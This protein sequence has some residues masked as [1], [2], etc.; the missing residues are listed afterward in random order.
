[1]SFSRLKK[2]S[3]VAAKYGHVRTYFCPDLRVSFGLC[4]HTLVAVA[5][6][7]LA[8][9]SPHF[10]ISGGGA[11]ADHEGPAIAPRRR[12]C[13]GNDVPRRRIINMFSRF[14]ITRHRQQ[15]LRTAPISGGIEYPPKAEKFKFY[16]GGAGHS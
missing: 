9:S 14:Q 6:G 16:Q 15:Y 11:K 5:A 7:Q 1:M 2:F 3:C 12:R 4:K 10:Q 13:G 8:A